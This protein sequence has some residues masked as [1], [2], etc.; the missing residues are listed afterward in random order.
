MDTNAICLTPEDQRVLGVLMEKCRTTPEQYPLS[1]NAVTLGC[2]QKTSRDP[3][4]DY[5]EGIV[6]RVLD[7]LREQ[8]L[9]RRVDE[10]GARVAKFRHIADEAWEL[11]REEYALVTV[12]LLR[13]PQTLGQLRQRTERLFMFRDLNQVRATLDAMQHREEGPACLTVALAAPPGSKEQRYGHMLGD[14]SEREAWETAA[15][16]SQAALP[17]SRQAPVTP[18][19]LPS[20][21]IAELRGEIED[22]R[23]EIQT[24][25]EQFTAFR[26][27]F[28]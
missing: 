27:E 16:S 12:L 25:K 6:L 19:P 7:R 1:L 23:G 21:V 22:L 9:A 14:P 3:V 4:V 17:A 11:S 8:G 24:L 18:Q 5:D 20:E 15:P 2:N 28:E 26:A 10:A 13:G